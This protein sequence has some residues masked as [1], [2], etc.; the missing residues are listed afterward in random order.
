ME[1]LLGVR[2]AARTLREQPAYNQRPPSL[3]TNP[4][5]LAPPYGKVLPKL[6]AQGERMLHPVPNSGAPIAQ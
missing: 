2:T 4:G 6:I 3:R 5:K 1:R